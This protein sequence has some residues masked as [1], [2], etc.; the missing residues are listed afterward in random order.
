MPAAFGRSGLFF[1]LGVIPTPVSS[2]AV[3]EWLRCG[4]VNRGVAPS[5]KHLSI[6]DS[7]PQCH[8]SVSPGHRYEVVAPLPRFSANPPSRPSFRGATIVW[9]EAMLLIVGSTLALLYL[10]VRYPDGRRRTRVR[11]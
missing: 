7:R 9:S 3:K 11:P 5:N 2:A 10:L 8:I 4:P 1:A 6:V